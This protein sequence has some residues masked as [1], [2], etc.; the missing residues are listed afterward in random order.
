MRRLQPRA[1]QETLPHRNWSHGMLV[2]L[3][4]ALA[5][6]AAGSLEAAEV[7][8]VKIAIHSPDNYGK[9]YLTWAPVPAWVRLS[10]PSE[11]DVAVV[12]TNDEGS[13]LLTPAGRRIDGDLAFSATQPP[14]GTT[15]TDESLHLTLPKSGS[16]V[17]IYLAGAFPQ[18]STQDQDAVIDVRLANGALAARR[19]T[20]VRVRKRFHTL[21]TEP[22]GGE[23]ERFFKAL[24]GLLDNGAEK[25]LHILSIHNWT[26]RGKQPNYPY[27]PYPGAPYPYNDQ[28][29]GGPAF[30]TWHRAYLLEVE[31]ELQ[32]SYPDIALPYWASNQPNDTTKVFTATALGF[33]PGTQVMTVQP[34]FVDG[35]PLE[36]WRMPIEGTTNWEPIQ[37]FGGDPYSRIGGASDDTILR[38]DDYARFANN[39]ESNPHN[40]GH[41]YTGPWMQDCRISP[42]DPI[43][44]VFH[45]WFDRMW[46]EWQKKYNRYDQSVLSYSPSGTFPPNA[47]MAPAKGHYLKDTMWP[48][49]D[50]I[51]NQPNELASRP[52]LKLTGPFKASGVAGIWPGETTTATPAPGDMID[53]AG[54]IAGNLN[55][56]FGY[57]DIPIGGGNAQL[58]PRGKIIARADALFVGND[59]AKQA[60]KEDPVKQNK[61]QA[62]G[63]FDSKQSLKQRLSA[64]AEIDLETDKDSVKAVQ[65]LLNDPKEHDALR[66]I[67]LKHLTHQNVGQ[68]LSK[69]AA[70]LADAND[71][72]EELQVQAVNS[73]G[74]IHMFNNNVSADELH[75]GHTALRRALQHKRPAV[76]SAALTVLA[77][78]KD[79]LAV[80]MLKD[81]LAAK[82]KLV[83]DLPST[84]NLLAGAAGQESHQHLRPFLNNADVVTR[85]AA[86][87]QL[88]NDAD[89]RPAITKLLR[90]PE[91]PQEVRAAA[92]EALL[93][94]D[95]QFSA[96]AFAL[97]ADGKTPESLRKKLIRAVRAHVD[98][99]PTKLSEVQQ[100]AIRA[101]L[102]QLKK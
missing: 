78:D 67:A 21:T 41:N 56:G 5:A 72:G 30:L 22:D 96:T 82:E 84:I 75:L 35:H 100:Q 61:S 94:H 76:K 86:V 54:T 68:T 15:C 4:G 42:R 65:K 87:S 2:P 45:S 66:A 39:I 44:W 57:D 34:Q 11:T 55:M 95:K 60:E 85:V 14:S 16:P 20:M 36:F 89:S 64:A 98:I 12:L 73:L 17:Q 50:V 18:A 25:Y 43:F 31:R 47:T 59:D 81:G 83:L 40:P 93:Y 91:Q 88:G 29:H 33:N 53:Y 26:A 74:F 10:K 101:K 62:S 63:F 9:V 3:L 52:P 1:T 79:E 48:W 70:I 24:A 69:A 49:N 90:D 6:L 99:N 102:D 77:A 19:A 58:P 37:R 7:Q 32:A 38:R 46:A 23:R 97:I 92:L 27:P 8:S 51:D 71:G 28:A 13:S 80:Q